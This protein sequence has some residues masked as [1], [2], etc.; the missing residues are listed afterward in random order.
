MTIYA[1]YENG[2]FRPIEAVDLPD[3]CTVEVE[4]RQLTDQRVSGATGLSTGSLDDV[5][6]VLADR[7]DTGVADLAQ[8]HDKHQP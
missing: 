6:A 8:S 3:R 5:Y 1:I 2:V 4:V 7:C